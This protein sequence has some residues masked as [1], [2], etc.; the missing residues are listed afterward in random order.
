VYGIK[1][2]PAPLSPEE[3][4]VVLFIAFLDHIPPFPKAPPYANNK[5][6]KA[7]KQKTTQ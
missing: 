4:E 3:N 6:L 5:T 1:K 7:I 2:A